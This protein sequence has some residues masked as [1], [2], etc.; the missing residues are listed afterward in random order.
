MRRSRAVP[1]RG[2][3]VGAADRQR[4]PVDDVVGYALP[5]GDPVERPALVEPAHVGDPF[6]DFAGAA[7]GEAVVSAHDR[8]RLEIDARRVVSIDGDFRFAGLAPFVERREIHERKPDRPL[9]LVD[10]GSG[11]EHD[12]VCGVD[13]RHRPAR[14]VGARV[15]E[16]AEHRLLRIGRIAHF[17]EPSTIQARP[18]LRNCNRFF[19]SW[20][21]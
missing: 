20:R 6:D 14:A 11:E 3:R 21:F 5:L 2:A 1:Q 15:G 7:D 17:S 4:Q 9:D 16:E 12:R 19:R 10:V 8:Q 18:R 13:A